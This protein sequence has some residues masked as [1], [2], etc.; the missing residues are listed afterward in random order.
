MRL[1]LCRLFAAAVFAAAPSIALGLCLGRMG[2]FLNGCCYGQVACAAIV[3]RATQAELERHC[4]A[5]L[6]GFKV[7]KRWVFLDAADVPFTASDKIDKAA[8]IEQLQD[9][10]HVPIRAEESGAAGAR[11]PDQVGDCAARPMSPH[12]SSRRAWRTPDL[13]RGSPARN[14]ADST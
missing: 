10:G 12:R 14:V 8:L 11:F 5:R 13:I 6:A 3:A 2:C 4:R 1:I 7:P 9:Q